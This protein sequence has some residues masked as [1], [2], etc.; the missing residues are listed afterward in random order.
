MRLMLSQLLAAISEETRA[1]MLDML[2]GDIL[3][4]RASMEMD[5]LDEPMHAD[6]MLLFLSDN[7]PLLLGCADS[8]RD[9]VLSGL[10]DAYELQSQAGVIPLT[11]Y[12]MFPTVS[13]C[14]LPS[15]TSSTWFW[16]PFDGR[17]CK[18]KPL[19][20]LS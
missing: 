17:V 2:R 13:D 9:S 12:C 1:R 16:M 7:M 11:S 5:K 14:F 4:H 15:K 19:T 18:A 3:A 6:N 20:S 8:Q 10:L